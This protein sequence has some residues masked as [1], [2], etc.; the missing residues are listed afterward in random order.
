MIS[1]LL[2][3]THSSEG[4]ESLK[5]L[6]NE[7][8]FKRTDTNFN[9]WSVVLVYICSPQSSTLLMSKL[10]RQRFI[11]DDHNRKGGPGLC[12]NSTQQKA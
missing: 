7:E 4:V 3:N 8:V 12:L 11:Q 9:F 5:K 10:N 2:F 6:L 1:C